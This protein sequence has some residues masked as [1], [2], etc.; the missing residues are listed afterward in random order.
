VSGVAAG[1]ATITATCE[2]KTGTSAITVT[3]VPVP[4]ASVTVSPTL[5]SV[6]AGSTTQ[7]T[8]TPKDA[9][10]TALTG[11]VVTW[12]S[13]NTAAA[14]V[15]GSGLVSGVA[16]G[17][18]TITA[19]CEGKTGTSAITVTPVGSLPTRFF[20]ADNI[21]NTD[22]SNLP[23]HSL[24]ATWMATVGTAGKNLHVGFYPDQYGMRYNIVDASTP[25]TTVRIVNQDPGDSDLIPYPFTAQTLFSL[26]PA[27]ERL[28][29]ASAAEVGIDTLAD[30][31]RADA[32]AG[33]HCILMPRLIGAWAIHAST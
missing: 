17:V 7:L 1:T 16:V 21:W 4:V 5:A 19:T 28:G 8:A 25:T 26:L 9:G 32:T 33:D 10:G 6:Q 31:L 20:P 30:R 12:S 11:R 24:S 18:A 15:N 27:M 13:N 29:I 2:G 23:V 3:S 22:I 14:T